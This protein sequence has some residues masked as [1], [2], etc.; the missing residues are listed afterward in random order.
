[1]RLVVASQNAPWAARF[2][3]MM[4]AEAMAAEDHSDAIDLDAEQTTC[5]ACASEF[6][7]RSLA[8]TGGRC[9]GCGL[10]LAG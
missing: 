7:P 1:M 9:P 10:Q 5:P 4:Q 2:L 8:E 6:D 3:Q